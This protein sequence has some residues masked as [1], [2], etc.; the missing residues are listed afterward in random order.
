M[1]PTLFL[2]IAALLTLLHSASH[3][4]NVV[5]GAPPPGAGEVA[6]AAMKANRFLVMG[7]TRSYWDF[8]MGLNLATTISLTIEAI[9]FWQ[10]G[11]LAKADSFRLRP[12][13]AAFMVGYLLMSVVTGTYIFAPPMIGEI[14]I[15]LCFGM[16]I[17]TSKPVTA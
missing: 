11:T 14:L 12:I 3:T 16:A 6:V 9:V 10:L 2:R 17:Y 8:L 5:F 13:Y 7:V 1:K 4:F 15:A